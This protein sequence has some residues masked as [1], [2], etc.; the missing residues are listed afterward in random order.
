MEIKERI[1]Q[2][3]GERHRDEGKGRRGKEGV[4]KIG[5]GRRRERYRI[6]TEVARIRGQL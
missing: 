2:R 4:K 3:E 1:K 6:R 5:M